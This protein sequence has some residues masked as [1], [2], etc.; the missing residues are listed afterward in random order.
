MSIE[1]RKRP[2]RSMLTHEQEC[3][4]SIEGPSLERI[5][6][7]GVEIRA[8]LAAMERAQQPKEVR[9]WN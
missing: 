3:K 9:S 8:K 6:Q 1:L 5:Q 7:L 4:L 2:I